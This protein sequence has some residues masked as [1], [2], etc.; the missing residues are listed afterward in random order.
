MT[1]P[2]NSQGFEEVADLVCMLPNV[3]PPSYLASEEH[4]ELQP[5][6]S[7]GC[8]IS[9]VKWLLPVVLQTRRDQNQSCTEKLLFGVLYLDPKSM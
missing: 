2:E 4:T 6:A 1:Q 3:Q 7:C 8:H 9:L 5:K